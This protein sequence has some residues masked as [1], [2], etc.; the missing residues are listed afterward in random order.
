VSV[1]YPLASAACLGL[2]LWRPHAALLVQLRDPT[3][4]AFSAG[5]GSARRAL[6]L[7][8]LRL[9]LPALGLMGGVVLLW[10]LGTNESRAP[11]TLFGGLM[12]TT[13][14][15]ISGVLSEKAHGTFYAELTVLP[16]C[17]AF[18]TKGLVAAGVAALG[19]LALGSGSLLVGALDYVRYL[20]S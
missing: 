8:E 15:G 3:A 16:V 13:L 14:A 1:I 6:L 18:W 17:Q 5:R 19:G 12:V 4:L 2:V 20:V 9:Q 10:L 11:L 7:K